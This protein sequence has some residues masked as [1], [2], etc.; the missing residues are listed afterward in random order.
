M[1]GRTGTG[2]LIATDPAAPFLFVA[3]SH[4]VLPSPLTR[5]TFVQIHPCCCD[6]PV[7][8]RP[9]LH[10]ATSRSASFPYCATHLVRTAHIRV[11]DQLR[12]CLPRS[13]NSTSTNHFCAT[14]QTGPPRCR[15]PPSRHAKPDLYSPW[16]YDK[17]DSPT[18]NQCDTPR[19]AKPCR[20]RTTGL[21]GSVRAYPGRRT[22]PFLFQPS[23]I[24]QVKMLKKSIFFLH[25][26]HLYCSLIFGGRDHSI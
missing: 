18:P 23:N 15:A 11:T 22:M 7:F 17:P 12:S 3:T 26:E 6:T 1:T 13:T 14:S 2:L 8:P 24:L 9:S 5:D 4:A 25:D 10:S 21:H 16:L 20:V 19:Y